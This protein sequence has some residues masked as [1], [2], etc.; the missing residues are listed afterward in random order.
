MRPTS[1]SPGL[2]TRFGSGSRGGAGPIWSGVPQRTHGRHLP[3]VAARWFGMERGRGL[4]F[5][6]SDRPAHVS[7]Q[8]K[9]G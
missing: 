6:V 4:L 9:R 1:R 5:G 2:W 8:K 7:K 3:R